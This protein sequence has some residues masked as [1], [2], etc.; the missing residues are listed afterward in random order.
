MLGDKLIIKEEHIKA[1]KGLLKL[2]L[3]KIKAAE[4]NNEAFGITIAGESGAGK[5]EV[6]V[7][8]SQQLVEMKV[9]SHILQQD[10]YFFYPPKTNDMMR[11]QDINHVGSSEV[12]LGLLDQNLRDILDGKEKV[13]K[14]LVAYEQ[15]EAVREILNLQGITVII[16][17]GTY[18]TLLKNAHQRVFIDRIYLETKAERLER[19]REE[20]DDYLEKILEIEHSIISKHKT[21]AD[22][23]VTRDFDVTENEE[24]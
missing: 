24:K 18:T 13:E 7:A 9:K 5:S 15:D 16:V 4:K 20:Q 21:K 1:A 10:D 23:L 17:E 2:L 22:I 19:G 14:P 6:A 11:R 12:N 8:M 3:P